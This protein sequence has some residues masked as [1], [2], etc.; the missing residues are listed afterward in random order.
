MIDFPCINY[1][2]K[3]T[4]FVLLG[5]TSNAN[6]SLGLPFAAPWTNKFKLSIHQGV[7]SNKTAGGFEDFLPVLGTPNSILFVDGG[8]KTSTGIEGLTAIGSGARL[9]FDG[10]NHQQMIVGAYA[11]TAYQSLPQTSAWYINPGLEFFK[12][13]QK[14]RIQYYH[15]L[16]SAQQPYASVLASNV[17]STID[18][19]AQ[20]AQYVARAS[21]TIV[22]TSGSLTNEFGQGFDVELSQYVPIVLQDWISFGAYY[23]SFPSAA[24][25][26]G[27]EARFKLKMICNQEDAFSIA[28]QENYDNQKHNAVALSLSYR[29]GGY[30]SKRSNDI[31]ALME[32]MIGH[33]V[34]RPTE[35]LITPVYNIFIPSGGVNNIVTDANWYFSSTGTNQNS[36]ITLNNCTLENPCQTLTQNIADGIQNIMPNASLYFETG[37]YNL[38]SN[39]SL[40]N[41]NAVLLSDGQQIYGKTLHWTQP[42]T[43]GNRPV[44]N[45]ALFWGNNSGSISERNATGRLDS[46]QIINT[47]VLIPSSVSGLTSD[48][49]NAVIAAGATGGLILNNTLLNV[50]ANS[51]NAQAIGGWT[52]NGSLNATANTINVTTSAAGSLNNDYYYGYGLY[53]QN[54]AISMSNSNTTV[55]TMGNNAKAYGVFSATQ[56]PNVSSSTIN[57]TT[58]GANADA[59][60]IYAALSGSNIAG[61]TIQ[62]SATGN[63]AVVNGVLNATSGFTISADTINVTASASGVGGVAFGLNATTNINSII[64][65]MNGQ[66]TINASGTGSALAANAFS[67]N[68]NTTPPSICITNGSSG[69][70]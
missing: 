51:A 38:P 35:A 20:I 59:S 49:A 41:A 8:Y 19:Q 14:I 11:F 4:L 3:L 31:S 15:P 58:A 63:N 26:K 2:K 27:V 22:D 62:A 60:G 57:V 12:H 53:S 23:F 54:G 55:S 61:T 52:L 68:N 48:T 69:T 43:G 9:L 65:F 6:A 7:D 36:T 17:P 25:I 64:T 66:S 37:T 30:K 50:T 47:N 1:K 21:H 40:N 10:P 33:D 42:A 56:Q 13:D 45:G 28:I 70:C 24:P 44:I 34:A 32:S 29:F 46:M 5:C 16:N 39:L 67:I 18:N